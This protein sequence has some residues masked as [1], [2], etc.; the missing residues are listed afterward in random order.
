MLYARVHSPTQYLSTIVTYF[1][2][3]ECKPLT[4]E[5]KY[6]WLNIAITVFRD[7]DL[8]KEIISEGVCVNIPDPNP[9]GFEVSPLHNCVEYD[10]LEG[11]SILVDAGANV[12]IRALKDYKPTPIHQAIVRDN[13]PMVKMLLAHGADPY[14]LI[15]GL[16]PV[17]N[18]PFS[19]DCFE[20]AKVFENEEMIS[21]FSG[22]KV[23]LFVVVCVDI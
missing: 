6:D 16:R 23:G 14:C 17:L 18:E 1:L 5:Q 20:M 11:V 19:W 15:H 7:V 13:L 22:Y 12:N 4:A 10:L 8:M 2:T 9:R 3:V 21:Y